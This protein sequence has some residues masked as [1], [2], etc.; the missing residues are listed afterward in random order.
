MQ[1]EEN[2]VIDSNRNDLI[3]NITAHNINMDCTMDVRGNQGGLSNI[4]EGGREMSDSQISL[5]SAVVITDNV[6][7]DIVTQTGRPTFYNCVPD[8]APNNN[9]ISLQS[10][11]RGYGDDS[12]DEIII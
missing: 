1:D 11:A 3:N 4:Y 6:R 2:I 5:Q 10:N 12:G 9:Q 8:T 7:T